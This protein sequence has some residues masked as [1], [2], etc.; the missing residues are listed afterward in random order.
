VPLKKFLILYL[1]L[2]MFS[3]LVCHHLNF[4]FLICHFRPLSVRGELDYML[5]YIF[6]HG[7]YLSSFTLSREDRAI[8]VGRPHGWRLQRPPVRPEP[9]HPYVAIENSS[10]PLWIEFGTLELRFAVL[11]LRSAVLK[12][13]PTHSN[14]GPQCLD[15]VQHRC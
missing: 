2:E 12:L 1:P 13:S 11:E 6:A 15:C 5:K 10:A 3:V 14:R 9:G 4:C 8:G 7:I